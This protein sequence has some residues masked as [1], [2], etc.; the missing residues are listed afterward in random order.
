MIV[1]DGHVHVTNRVY[2]EGIDP[3]QPRAFGFDY[4][5]AFGSGVNVVIENIAPYGYGN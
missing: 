2:W 4:A 1:I 3:W 5:R